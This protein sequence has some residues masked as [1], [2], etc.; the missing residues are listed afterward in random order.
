[1]VDNF[2]TVEVSGTPSMDPL[3]AVQREGISRMR[4]SLLA[5]SLDNPSSTKL[6]MQQVTLLRVYHQVN[7][8]IKYLDLMDKLEEKLYS[9][10]EYS[11]DNMSTADP[12]TWRILL[13]AQEELQKNMV[14]SQKLLSPY[15]DASLFDVA[16]YILPESDSVSSP[17]VASA[18]SRERIRNTAQAVLLQLN[19]AG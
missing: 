14:E 4:A 9:S 12:T 8:I 5:C 3:S 7:R 6:A 19:A 15:L 11:I 17:V 13:K 16:D 2:K 1:M 10:L 18:E